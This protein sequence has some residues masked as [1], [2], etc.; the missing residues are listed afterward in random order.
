MIEPT[1]VA[2]KRAFQGVHKAP[3][4][5]PEPP[6]ATPPPKPD[7]IALR[8]VHAEGKRQ[9]KATQRLSQRA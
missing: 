3:P 6:G 7:V 5:V 4:P 8:R 9:R 2:P 1:P